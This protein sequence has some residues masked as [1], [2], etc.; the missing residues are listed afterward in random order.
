MTERLNWT[1]WLMLYSRSLLVTYFLNFFMYL[2]ACIGSSLRHSGLRCIIKLRALLLW[3]TDSLVLECGLS[4]SEA[5]G[6]LVPQPGDR[7]QS[8]ALHGG[9]L[10]TE[11]PGKSPWLSVWYVIVW[12]VFVNLNLLIYPS[13]QPLFPFG[14]HKFVFCVCALFL[15]CM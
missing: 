14:Y 9:F 4:C 15:F 13:S 12:Y 6:I 7:T 1:D 8:P 10:T 3:Y 2:F 5:C 11:P